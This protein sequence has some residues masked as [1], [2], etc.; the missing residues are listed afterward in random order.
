VTS[1]SARVYCGLHLYGSAVGTASIYSQSGEPKETV[2]KTLAALMLIA[3]GLSGCGQTGP[4]YLPVSEQSGS[5]QSA[6]EQPAPEQSTSAPLSAL[7]QKSELT[8][9]KPLESE[10]SD[11]ETSESD[12]QLPEES[13]NENSTIQY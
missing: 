7:S 13:V 11:S 9:S 12:K 4:L 8:E 5:E 2:M 3:V 1:A 6:S 10:L